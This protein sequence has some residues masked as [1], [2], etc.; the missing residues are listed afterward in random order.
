MGQPVLLLDEPLAGLDSTSV[1]VLMTLLQET[2]Q[3][4]NQTVLMISHQRQGLTGFVDYDSQRLALVFQ[5]AIDQ[6]VTMTVA[7]E[8]ALS[9][10]FSLQATYWTDDR[11]AD[12]LE[13]LQL[14]NLQDHVVYQLS[15]G[16]F[17]VAV[18]DRQLLQ[19]ATFTAPAGQIGLISGANG[20]GKSTFF[21]GLTH[22]R[23]YDG[24]IL[25]ETVDGR[26]VKQ[27]H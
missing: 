3:Q 11:V 20:I 22:Q 5:S 7:S 26:K 19:D 10:K 13:K 27:K 12:A 4:T 14:S 8:I 17:G 21:K 6:F 2:I 23:A 1:N 15:G 24:Q 16:H 18:G 25:W 9:K